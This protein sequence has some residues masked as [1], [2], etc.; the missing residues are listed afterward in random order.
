S[1]VSSSMVK[2]IAALGGDARQFVP[3]V[4]AAALKKKLAHS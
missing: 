2:E 1:Y 4:V 3:P